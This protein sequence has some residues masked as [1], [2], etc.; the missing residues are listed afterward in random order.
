[1]KNSNNRLSYI[2]EYITSYEAKIKALNKEG[3]FDSAKLFEL[4]AIGICKLWFKQD[5]YNLN[6]EKT[7]YPYVDLVSNDKEI[8]VQVSTQQNIPNKIKTTLEKIK[9][10]KSE[11]SSKIKSVYFFVLNNCSISNV[12]DYTGEEKIG[13]IEFEKCKHLVTTQDIVKKAT[14]DL[15]F[16]IALYD[17][18]Q[19]EDSRVKK[20]SN[21]LFLEIK[22]SKEIG[23]NNI[24]CLINNEYE[25]DRTKIIEKIKSSK[26]QFL[27]IRG[28][29]GSGKSAIC[30]RTV[31]NEQYLLFARAERFVEESDINDIW[32]VNLQDS[33]DLLSDKSMVIFIDS[34]EFI[35]DAPKTKLDLL[36]SLYELVKEY[37]NVKIITS[38]RI[39]D[40]NAFIK[41]DSKYS[42][43]TFLVENLSAIELKNASKKYPILKTFVNDFK[44]VDLVRS[45]FYVDLIVKNVTDVSSISDENKL[46]DFIWENVICLK[47]KTHQYDVN[48]N[49][50]V[51]EVKNLVF[52]RSELFLLGVNRESI[53]QKVL[54]AL[55]S[56]NVLIENGNVFRLKYD[57]FEDICFE[58]EIDN[59][60]FECRSDYS[61]LFVEIE[62]FG[63]CCYRR[64]QIWISNKLFTK[65]NRDKFLFELISKGSLQNKWFTQ[66][67]IGI[68]KSR[69]CCQF[70]E[71]Q[72][73]SII[74]NNLLERFI[75]ITNLY[76][77]EAKVL[78]LK[79]GPQLL[80]QPKGNGRAAIIK[81]IYE[82]K[83]YEKNTVNTNSIIKLCSDYAKSSDIKSEL[84][85]MACLILEF[86]IAKEL[87]NYSIHYQNYDIIKSLLE[88]IYLMSESAHDWICDF[89]EKQI[90][91]FLDG[92]HKSQRFAEE[93]IE[94]TLKFT[95]NSLA[96][97]H[98][99]ELCDLANTFWTTQFD[100][101]DSV[102]YNKYRNISYGYGLNEYADDYTRA[103]DSLYKHTFFNNLL[104]Q[105]FWI[106]FNWMISFINNAVLHYAECEEADIR[107]ITICLV[108]KNEEKKYYANKDMWLSGSQEC[109]FPTLLGD[110]VYTLKNRIIHII[111]FAISSRSNFDYKTYADRIK[112]TILENANNITL[113][114]IVEDIGIHF[115]KEIPGFA[116]DLAT[117][118][119]IIYW[120]INRYASLNP[121]PEAKMLRKNI[122]TAMCVPYLE[123]RYEKSSKLDYSL[124]DYVSRMQF[125]GETREHC[126]K[127]LDYLYTIY[128]NDKE[129]AHYHLQIQKMDFRNAGVEIVDKQT[130]ALSPTITGA[131]KKVVEA[132]IVNNTS[133]K[134]I[135]NA[136]KEFT[137]SLNPNDYNSNDV[138]KYIDIF[139][140]EI[141]KVDVPFVYNEYHVMLICF[142]LN[143]ED[144][145][146]DKRNKYC[147]FWINGV[148][149]VLENNSFSFDSALLFVLLRQI[150]S[151][152]STE[153]KNR[154]KRLILNISTYNGD[155]GLVTRLKNVTREFLK[156]N[157]TIGNVIFNTIIMLA[158]D[159][160]KHQKFNYNFIV[161]SGEDGGIEFIPNH[162]PKLK[163]VDSRLLQEGITGYNKKTEEIVIKYLYCEEKLDLSNL[164][165]DDLDINILYHVV[166][167]EIGRAHV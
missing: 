100:N 89:L 164:C 151:N 58:K 120:D 118:M 51:S 163:G 12:K 86:Y 90:S 141:K 111:D 44:Y 105:N 153:I 55:L 104:E 134:N 146:S 78:F 50:I 13:E 74:T 21:Q 121:T 155:N 152:A 133:R 46:R 115:E 123:D 5:F 6:N 101:N 14:S 119:E 20:I 97:T 128:P 34:L 33:L 69:F 18:L 61:K 64:Y 63:R 167:C 88:P 16:Q 145:A 11:K 162:T 7:N 109:H 22:N 39:S 150:N 29:A 122:F 148:Q 80:L 28:E 159:E 41:I 138:I 47:N 102:Y 38:C 60:F 140:A 24:D 94:Y 112:E 81:I 66:T 37:P 149:S 98:A 17:L 127:V 126:Y 35:A 95:P 36:Q 4:F 15:E 27:S 116:L 113:F 96:K 156:T 143:K 25:I 76:A 158:Q 45:P 8:F 31:E 91:T 130:I 93:I 165:I 19:K 10:D 142:A 84:A 9:N 87:K 32:H 103:R 52:K 53:N 54:N 85:N 117:S 92:K 30:K 125:N 68:V 62:K 114:S 135:E 137:E 77:F 40:Q 83:L 144:L 75:D 110:M 67:I 1:M 72:A 65:T 160:M 49:E 57:I 154:L 108:A 82:N 71:E 166:Y 99:K 43:E 26:K 157:P 42:V 70:F 132:N 79:V 48:F 107:E 129:N 3:L 147:D 56:E 131:A 106:G 73:N 23:L 139:Q 136:I 2:T 124:Q 59:I 161:N